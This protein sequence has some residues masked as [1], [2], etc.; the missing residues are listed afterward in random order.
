MYIPCY[1]THAV[2]QLHCTNFDPSDPE[3]HRL[4]FSEYA[5]GMT[6]ACCMDPYWVLKFRHDGNVSKLRGEYDQILSIRRSKYRRNVPY[7]KMLGSVMVQQRV[8]VLSDNTYLRHASAI[9]RLSDKLNMC[10][11]GPGN[12]GYHQGKFIFFDIETT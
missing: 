5:R 2:Q 9:H 10:D 11:I 4:G 1:V 12:V 6:R 3:L 7:T 8:T